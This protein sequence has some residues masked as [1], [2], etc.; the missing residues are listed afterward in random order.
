MGFN[1]R[2]TPCMLPVLIHSLAPDLPSS[3]LLTPFSETVSS[4]DLA[5]GDQQKLLASSSASG[6]SLHSLGR[7]IFIVLSRHLTVAETW[8]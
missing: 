5:S 8:P 1:V 3:A 6:L 2:F 7:A 4:Y